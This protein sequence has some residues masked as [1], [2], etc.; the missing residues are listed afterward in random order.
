[1]SPYWML[2]NDNIVKSSSDPWVKTLLSASIWLVVL[3]AVLL[4]VYKFLL[5]SG[6]DTMANL[7]KGV[8]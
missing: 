5:G 7:A 2:P 4:G 1:M 3:T 8:I 6:I